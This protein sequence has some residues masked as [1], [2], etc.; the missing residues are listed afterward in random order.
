MCSA[1]P[2]TSLDDMVIGETNAVAPLTELFGPAQEGVDRVQ[3]A[4]DRLTVRPIDAA[5]HATFAGSHSASFLQTPNWADVKP[6]WRAES[7]GWFEGAE[8]VGTALVLYRPVP[9]TNRSLAYLPEGPT[10]PWDQ[11]NKAPNRWLDPM[12]AH[13][14]AQHAFAVRMGPEPEVRI[15]KAATAKQGLT[16]P[17]ILRFADLPPDEVV[18]EGEQ[19][20]STLTRLGWKPVDREEGFGGGQPRFGVWVRLA[21]RTPAELLADCNQQ[22]RRNVSKSVKAGVVVREGSFDDLPTFHR[23]YSETG[24][25]DGFRPRPASYFTRMWR[26]LERG[27]EPTLRLYIGEYGPDKIPLCAAMVVQV[28]QVCWYSYGASTS[29]HRE[30]QASTAVQWH[31]ILAAQAR[32]AFSYNL[33]GVAD[34]LDEKNSLAGLLRFKLGT[35][36][37]VVE[38]AGEWELPLS[39]LWNTAFHLYMKL[40]S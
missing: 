31:A 7:L 9:K 22:W 40:R 28:G 25:R 39:P 13:L 33:R 15:W 11:V 1:S 6:D 20:V 27:P 37:S 19:L 36:G 14:R 12:I 16:D 30:A 29:E 18:P 5:L 8:L 26:S 24:A 38:A 17:E 35:G 34:T 3:S 2:G 4:P 10:L 32:G 21:N 23:L